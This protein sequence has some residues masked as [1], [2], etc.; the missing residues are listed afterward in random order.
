MYWR[1]NHI[2][3]VVPQHNYHSTKQEFLALKWMF[4]EQFQENL[5][6]KQ[7]VLKTDNNPLTYI[8]TT[9]NLEATQHCWVESMAG[10]TFSTEYQ[11]GRDNAVAD[12]LSH[13][14]SKLNAVAVNSIL[15]GFTIGTAGRADTHDPMV[16]EADKRIH[17]QVE[18]TAV[19]VQ[20]THMHVNLHV[21]D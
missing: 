19:Q 20:A 11:K 6:W 15:D 18:E 21:M 2:L 12:V 16:A 7:F 4:V 1:V 8:L 10:F 13:V 14:W 9:P 5:Q 3:V 17:K